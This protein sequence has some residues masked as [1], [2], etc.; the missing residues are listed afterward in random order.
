MLP[1][2]SGVY[3]SSLFAEEALRVTLAWV[4]WGARMGYLS[5]HPY[6]GAGRRPQPRTGFHVVREG[7]VWHIRGHRPAAGAGRRCP[8][9]VIP[10]TRR[11][12]R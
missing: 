6:A 10:L 4:S 2:W 9:Q 3:L 1:Y 11:A 5:Y 8:G 7:N 12:V